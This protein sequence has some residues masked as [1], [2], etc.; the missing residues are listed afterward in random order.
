MKKLT[1][2]DWNTLVAAWRYYEYRHTISSATFPEEVV[3]HFFAGTHDEESCK[4]IAHQFAYIDHGRRG[5]EDWED[6]TG[7]GFDCDKKPWQKFYYFCKAYCDG[8]TDVELMD[9]STVKA[10]YNTKTD[11]W[12]PLDSYISRPGTEIFISP[13]AIVKVV[14]K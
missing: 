10:F 6:Q 4:Q 13:D 12:I 11:R 9:G 1:E 14:E 5:A 3:R 8:F 2:W 7:T